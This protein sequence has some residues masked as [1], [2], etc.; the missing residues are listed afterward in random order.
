MEFHGCS[1]FHVLREMSFNHLQQLWPETPGES[2][3]HPTTC[4]LPETVIPRDMG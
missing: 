2:I 4:L 3:T 1:L